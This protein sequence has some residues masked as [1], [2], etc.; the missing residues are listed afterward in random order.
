MFFFSIRKSTS[1]RLL[2]NGDTYTELTNRTTLAYITTLFRP[3]GVTPHDGLYG[4]APLER[5]IFF[6]LQ[7]Y[8]RVGVWLV[9]AYGRVG[10][11]SFQSE[12][13]AQE[14]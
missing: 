12:K 1:T 10:N 13:E 7:V 5:G 6:R 14:G 2:L 9:E 11:R 8:E 3:L 4:E